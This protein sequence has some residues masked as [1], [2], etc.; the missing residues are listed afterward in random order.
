MP[1]HDKIATQGGR[2][3]GI[4]LIAGSIGIDLELTAYRYPGTIVALALDAVVGAGIGAAG[5][6]AVPH[7]DKIAIR[8]GRHHGITL[9]VGGVGIDLKL[10]AYRYPATVVALTL[11]AVVVSIGAAGA[12]AVPYDDKIATRIGPPPR[13]SSDC[14][15]Y[16]N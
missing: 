7:N 4:A 1:H 12:I 8:G 15:W 11:D 13:D 2:H 9:I 16:R 6:P 5:A 10:T 14:W 3:R